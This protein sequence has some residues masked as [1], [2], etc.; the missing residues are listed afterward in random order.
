MT[1]SINSNQMTNVN[2]KIDAQQ[3]AKEKKAEKA[4]ENEAKGSIGKTDSIVIAG[5]TGNSGIYLKTGYNL[6]TE[7]IDSVKGQQQQ[8]LMH[9]RNLVRQMI[10]KQNKDTNETGSNG[11][12]I[13]K[14]LSFGETGTEAVDSVKS[15]S[16][17]EDFSVEAVS[18]KIVDFA[19]SVSGGDK[20]KLAQLK[21]AIE[22]GFKQASQAFGKALPEISKQ[23]HDA[24]MEKLDS[25]SKEV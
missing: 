23:T 24:I 7:E 18:K 13:Q 9:L 20:T 15:V 4:S 17:A 5:T 2:Y 12:D 1:I 21:A 8:N 10:M 11:L 14:I 19:I 3:E 25:W 6:T 22:E 16:S